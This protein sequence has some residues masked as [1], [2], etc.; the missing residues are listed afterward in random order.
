[1]VRERCPESSSLIRRLRS[2]HPSPCNPG[3]SLPQAM[4]PRGLQIAYFCIRRNQDTL[5]QRGRQMQ[6][7]LA[8]GP[9]LPQSRHKNPPQTPPLKGLSQVARQKRRI[10]RSRRLRQSSR[11]RG[12]VRSVK[13]APSSDR[14]CFS[15]YPPTGAQVA[16]FREK[17]TK[18]MVT[19]LVVTQER[20]GQG[21]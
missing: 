1:M 2:R 17:D 11:R 18:G 16:H 7:L 9:L 4:P 14:V 10:T 21:I 6:R 19:L 12:A 20:L 8:R 15:A 5:G 3:C 13:V